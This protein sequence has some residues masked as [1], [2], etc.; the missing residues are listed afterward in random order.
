MINTNKPTL[1]SLRLRARK[2]SWDIRIESKLISEQLKT[3]RKGE[4][5][6]TIALHLEMLHEELWAFTKNETITHLIAE[7]KAITPDTERK[8]STQPAKKTAKNELRRKEV[9][10]DKHCLAIREKLKYDDCKKCTNAFLVATEGETLKLAYE[11]IKSNPGN[12]VR[13][14]D[15]ITLDGITKEWFDETSRKLRR[16]IYHPLPGR[17][18]YIPKANGKRRPLGISSPRDKIIQQAFKIIMEEVL[19]PRFLDTS[20]GF[21]PMRGCHTALKNIR[22]WQGVPW[23]IEGDIKSEGARCARSLAKRA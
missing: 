9:V 7:D 1:N 15:T 6:K 5:L 13:G 22:S 21:R 16:E 18:V 12:M 10:P 8:D 4:E 3:T 17:R 19:E 2:I 23:I 11:T 20:H 14:T